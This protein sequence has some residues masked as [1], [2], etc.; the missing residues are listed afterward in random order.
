MH[1]YVLIDNRRRKYVKELSKEKEENM[2]Q[3]LYTC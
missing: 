1:V 2:F 3:I